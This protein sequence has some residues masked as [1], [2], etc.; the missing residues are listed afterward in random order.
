MLWQKHVVNGSLVYVDLFKK[1]IKSVSNEFSQKLET[2]EE[3]KGLLIKNNTFS[4]EIRLE[5][6]DSFQNGDY[7]MAINAYNRALTLAEADTE[8]MGI[9]FANRSACF[10]D[11]KQYKRCV[12][13]IELAIENKCPERLMSKLNQRKENS[14]KCLENQTDEMELCHEK[15]KLSF[16][17]HPQYP[18]FANELEVDLLKEVGSNITANVD[19]E[20][21]QTICIEKAMIFAPMGG[22]DM[23]YCHYCFERN[24]NLIPCENCI[25]GMFCSPDC[26]NADNN[27]HRIVC[28]TEHFFDSGIPYE[29]LRSIIFAINTFS[30][31]ENLMQSIE[32]FR[33]SAKGVNDYSDP[34]KRQ[35]FQF[36]GLRSNVHRMSNEE[37]IQIKKYAVEV[38][39][40]MKHASKLK[41]MF[42]S[43][44]YFLFLSHLSLHH[45]EIICSIGYNAFRYYSGSAFERTLGIQENRP[46]RHFGSGILPYSSQL[47][48]SCTPNICRI[49]AKDVVVYRVIRPIK[50][51]EQLFVS[52]LYVILI[53]STLVHD[54]NMFFFLL[55]RS[56]TIVVTEKCSSRASV[57]ALPF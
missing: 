48:H 55:Q 3:Q 4:Q 39:M 29:L 1:E 35:Y 25:I 10:F 5:G 27:Y 44:K 31:V 54:T 6:N 21:G 12:A 50:R 49:F 38:A 33:K 51:G 47:K 30:T 45:L 43:T 18:C 37:K 46:Q 53:T 9:C 32:D 17:P 41:A 20:I 13:D 7:E 14:L 15:P 26:Y 28:C 19:L 57:Q 24:V 42:Q 8:A 16:E 56:I 2:F 22:K 23:G 52:Y 36:F 40:F 34:A 11:L